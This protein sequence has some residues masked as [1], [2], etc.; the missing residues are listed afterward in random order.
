MCLDQ[1]PDQSNGL[2]SDLDCDVCVDEGNPPQQVIAEQMAVLTDEQIDEVRFW[3]GYFPSDAGGGEP[4]PD[5]FMVKFRVNDNSTGVALPGVV[6]SSLAVGPATTRTATGL[7]LFGVREFEYTVSLDTSLDLPAALYWVEIYNDTTND[8]TDDD[9]FWEAGT[10]HAVYGRSGSA[11][12]VDSPN[13]PPKSWDIHRET[14][15]ALSITCKGESSLHEIVLCDSICPPSTQAAWCIYEVTEV[16]S[17]P[18]D[19]NPDGIVNGAAICVTPCTVPGDIA[20]CDPDGTGTAIF[21]ITD[22]D[23][24]FRVTPIDGCT[25]CPPFMPKWRR[26]N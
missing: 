13:A 17:D 15:L 8:P 7:S 22:D 2:F 25:T 6:V 5:T 21:Q 3:G 19:C 4:P 1:Q 14:D 12:S 18:V 11:F 24:L 20:E 26:I 10:L 9:W 23:C 16:L